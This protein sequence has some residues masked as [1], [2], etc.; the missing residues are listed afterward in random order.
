M[1]CCSFYSDLRSTTQAFSH[2]QIFIK[3]PLC[4]RHHSR[5]W[6]YNK[7]VDADLML[8]SSQF[9]GEDTVKY[10]KIQFCIVCLRG[11]PNP[12][13]VEEQ[14]ARLLKQRATNLSLKSED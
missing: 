12:E 9:S 1:E 4:S 3:G 2:S 5:G 14:Q 6:C 10:T 8:G 7:E 13:L 11:T